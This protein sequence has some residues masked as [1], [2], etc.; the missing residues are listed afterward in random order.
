MSLDFEVQNEISMPIAL[1]S[2]MYMLYRDEKLHKSEG[3]IAI[4]FVEAALQ[5]LS[6]FFDDPELLLEYG[7]AAFLDPRQQDLKCIDEMFK[8]DPRWL[9]IAQWELKSAD[10]FRGC[11][12]DAVLKYMEQVDGVSGLYIILYCCTEDLWFTILV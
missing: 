8:P 3:M 6:D 2:V 1:E 5:K 10:K 7:I 4:A 12:H 11:V 9:R